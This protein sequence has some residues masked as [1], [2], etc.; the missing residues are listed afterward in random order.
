MRYVVGL[1]GGG[2]QTTVAVAEVSGRELLRYKGPAGLVDPRH[3]E[4]S[5]RALAKTVREA[6]ALAGIG[7]Q[8]AAF[9]AGLAGVGNDAERDVVQ[10]TL[11]AAG[12]AERVTVRTDGEIALEG[13]FRGG[14]G[15]LLI[16][17]TG[18]VAYGRGE[19][20]RT[21]RCGGWGMIVGDEGS[22]YWIG[23]S[24]LQRALCSDDG[25]AEAT[26]LLP[27]LLEVLSLAGPREIPPW[28]GRATKAHIAALVPHVVAL[29]DAGD[30]AAREILD[31]AAKELAAHVVALGAR[32]APWSEPTPVVL[33]GGVLRNSQVATGIAEQLAAHGDA[34]DVRPP[35]ADAVAGALDFA[36][37]LLAGRA[38]AGVS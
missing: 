20:G 19:D 16:A 4:Q 8:S 30:T 15:I 38:V 9:C 27:R 28:A 2:T 34:F 37:A 32:L 18:S 35:A 7:G 26:G 31:D 23:R 17:G 29:A 33:L 3:P 14:P 24:A 22:G 25:R 10:A 1:D 5:A 6:L 36:R 13:A 11:A 21:A 12:I